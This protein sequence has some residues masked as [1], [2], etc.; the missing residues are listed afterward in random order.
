MSGQAEA[1]IPNPFD[2]FD[3]EGSDPILMEAPRPGLSERFKINM[4]AATRQGTV[5]GALRDVSRPEN[6]QR[7]DSRYE[8]F[9][10]WD[11]PIEGLAALTGQVAGT[12]VDAER[13]TPHLENLIP[14]GIGEKA[15][16]MS[17]RGLSAL[18]ARLFAGAVDAAA[19]NAVTDP[20]IQGI[21]MGA[22][23]REEFDP[24]Q[25]ASS[26]GLGAV[27]G[28]VM[29]PITHRASSP[30]SH[31]AGEVADWAN[32]RA[33][34]MPARQADMLDTAVRS[35][36]MDTPAMNP[37]LPDGKK[38]DFGNTEAATKAQ[39]AVTASEVVSEPV[40]LGDRL[41]PRP[42]KP[43][44]QAMARQTDA[45]PLWKDNGTWKATDPDIVEVGQ[46]GPI[47]DID[48]H[49][50][51]WSSVADRLKQ[52]E[53]GEARGA[54]DHPDLGDIDVFWG[55]YD[56]KTDTGAGLKKIFEK[57]P[58]VYDDLPEIIRSLEVVSKSDNRA[59]LK[60]DKYK[61]VIRFDYDGKEKTW[62]LSAYEPTDDWRARGTTGRSDTYHADASSAAPTGN[63][64]D[65]KSKNF[66]ESQRAEGS[67]ERSDSRQ[68]DAHSSS[69]SSADQDMRLPQGES[70]GDPALQAAITR[71][72]ADANMIQDRLGAMSG[73][74]R[75][76]TDGIER[77]ASNENHK[78]VGVRL[79]DIANRLYDLTGVAA[80]RRGIKKPLGQSKA[81]VLGTH[82]TRTGV[83]RIKDPNDIE[84][85]AHEVGHH[86]D[87]K[88]GKDFS[89]LMAIYSRELEPMAPVGY[90]PDLWLTEGF[91]EF[92]RNFLMNPN[93]A[94]KHAPTFNRAFTD[95]LK[96]RKP[97]WLKG[98]VELQDL[99]YSW[100]T[101]PSGNAVSSSVVTS[102][103]DGAIGQTIEEV[104]KS[105][106]GQTIGDKLHNAYTNF[107]DAKHPI[108]QAVTELIKVY[109][110]NTG[111]Q[112]DLA[113]KDDPYKLARM[114][115]GAQSA[116]HMDL[117]YGVHGYH[118]LEPQGPALRDAIIYAHG[119]GNVLSKHDPVITQD[120]GTY[121]W[122]R[123]ALGEWYRYEAGDI[124]NTPDKFTKGDHEVVIREMEAKYPHFQQAA[125][126]V[127][128]WNKQLWKKKL[129]AGLISKEQYREG[130]QIRDYVPG[131]RKQD[132]PGNTKTEGKGAR[133]G[134][135][136]QVNQ[137][138]GS[139][140]D[141]INPLESLMMDAYETSVAIAHNDMIRS[142]KRLGRMAGHG[143]GAIVEEIPAR[144]MKALIVDPIEAVEA[145]A[146]QR[147]F[148]KVDFSI[149][150][151]ALQETIGN[152]K[153]NLFRPEVIKEGGQPIVFFR[154]GGT[155]KAL[156]LADGELGQQ[157]YRSF[158]AMNHVERTMLLDI[159]AG[160]ASMLRTGITAAPEFI[161]ANIIRDQAMAAIFYGHPF[162]RLKA[163]FDGGM[164]EFF[165]RE[166]AR[167]YNAMG[168]IMGGENVASLRD[169]ALS[170][171]LKA[172]EKKGYITSK[173]ANPITHPY[174][175][176][177]GLASLTEVSETATRLGLFRTFFEE[178]RMRGLDE[179]EAATE[180]AW[181]SRDHLDFDRRGLHMMALSRIVPFLNASLQGLDKASRLMITP[182][183]KKYFGKVLTAEE[184]RAIPQAT[185]AWARLSAL[186]VAGMGLHA[187]M[188][189]YDDYHEI[190][191][192]TRATHWMIK[193]GNRWT[194]IPKP[195]ELAIMLNIAE[196]AYDG[197]INQD[198]TAAE[199]YMDS[200]F[201][202]LLP[203]N[204]ME[205]NPLVKTYFE[206]K[207]NKD[208]FTGADVV[209][210]QLLGLEP[211]LQ[212]TA[213]TSELSK[214]IGDVLGWSPALTDKM[215]TNFTG[216]LGR[217]ALSIYDAFG[218]N[219]PGQSAD[220]MAILR[221]FIKSAS[222][223]SRST[224]EFWALVAPSTGEFEG[225]VKSYQ[226]MLDAG[227]T[228]EAD[229]YLGT[230]GEEQRVYLTSRF[231]QG[232]A[233]QAKKMHPL[234][235]A[236]RAVRAISRLRKDLADDEVIGADGPL[237]SI[238][239]SDRGAMVDILE[240][241][242]VKEARNALVLLDQPGWQHRGLMDVEG[243]YRELEALNPKILK[244]LADRYATGGVVPFETVQK[245]WPDY[246][247]RLL[248]DGSDAPMA[249]FVV[250][251]KH[252]RE[253]N[254]DKIKRPPKALVP[255]LAN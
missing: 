101:M 186:T 178:G 146:K 39:S 206:V 113:V 62:L 224:R 127:Y 71:V 176:A 244:V 211:R 216:G 52:M 59:I 20:V 237:S 56:L 233:A 172:L 97:E 179:F 162:K 199:R 57:H 177:K 170:R 192:T 250:M 95:F 153:A 69:T 193:T 200:L 202:V 72:D 166:A 104:K 243:H 6:R 229:D 219:K 124:P 198:P 81:G 16:A 197:V 155:L 48:A 231:M 207:S 116:G 53:A 174:Q 87:Q 28:G 182:L 208:F 158:T 148:S 102:K 209:P 80:V 194:A 236:R 118:Q 27:A 36:P 78:A 2:Q 132:Y 9:P 105:G 12:I 235:R 100:R 84:V 239:R 94:A 25:F 122:S 183:A 227:Q 65:P 240:S 189:Q 131:L 5:V 86:I 120:F 18:R 96:S 4:E 47:V 121:L 77:T 76:N 50:R 126:M 185:K 154:E 138:R 254:G 150:R 221:R 160:S 75:R 147:G 51:Q 49:N 204:I 108:Q 173:M 142:L 249:D 8:S 74:I 30:Q 111:K 232:N 45:E 24:I 41:Q 82:N 217:S 3:A 228:V 55:D 38:L 7:F 43:E 37:D 31:I 123:R 247:A 115:N 226:A 225:T 29:G 93:Y 213:S 17:G 67:T 139:N 26:V 54:L 171:D 19:V 58:E 125:E 34:D 175:F 156:R 88:L 214:Q 60:S 205:S 191:E 135:Q 11:T 165:S 164:D 106:I 33:P 64:I 119:G 169:G 152:E 201:E 85:I 149:V 144:E 98:F 68:M 253:L 112:L 159:L 242:A 110:E 92:F 32:D 210:E 117:M 181:L 14:V 163:T 157:L 89:D 40:S 22:G 222:R 46:F 245:S 73:E 141:V 15:L 99:Y 218:S 136:N 220:D 90:S 83:I 1:T 13:G 215:I 63:S 252:E 187:L 35:E 114:I 203:P 195:F 223:G 241:L 248:A 103:I 184:E 10:E 230:L 128:G 145:A 133:T 23:F 107:M 70:K 238:P 190:S 79:V 130:L 246:R 143:S 44:V 109:S 140:L 91:A 167:H 180:A 251:A 66:N 129:D 255:G 151:D 137:F 42:A 21:E 212:Y 188:S 61:A 196:A 134:K 168:G 161:A 234:D